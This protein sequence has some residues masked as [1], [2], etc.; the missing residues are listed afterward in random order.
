MNEDQEEENPLERASSGQGSGGAAIRTASA[1]R[2]KAT[3]E[4]ENP[5]KKL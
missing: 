1:G 4:S 5:R 2:I 3:E